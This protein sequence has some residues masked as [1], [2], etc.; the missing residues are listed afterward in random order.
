M[1]A[2]IKIIDVYG[3]FDNKGEMHHYTYCTSDY[4]LDSGWTQ[5]VSDL[6]TELAPRAGF[7]YCSWCTKEGWWISK[8]IPNPHDSRKDPVMLSV[9]IG[10]CRPKHGSKAVALLDSF[11]DFFIIQKIWDDKETNAGF[12]SQFGI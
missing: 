11:V 1:D 3:S 2:K 7:Y 4:S 8:V 10:K 6:R 5:H 12:D 9:C